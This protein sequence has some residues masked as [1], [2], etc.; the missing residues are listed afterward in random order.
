MLI[1]ELLEARVQPDQ[2][3]LYQV[4]EL[5]DDALREYGAFLDSNNDVDDID[6]LVELLNSYNDEDELPVE[7]HANHDPRK[8]PDEWLSAS[9]NWSREH[10]KSIDVF[11]H[12][13]NLE[14]V[15][16]PKTFK[17]VLMRMLGHELIHF[18]QYDKMRPGVI[19]N[20]RSGHMKGTELAAKTGKS[21]DWM[22][23]YLRDPH[24]IMAYAHDLASELRDL[25]DPAAALR[26][27]EAH[28]SALTS[29]DRYRQVF[30]VNSPQIRS[31]LKYAASYAQQ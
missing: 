22:R 6:E 15:Y 7:F 2:R 1:R 17:G 23:S 30:P 5:I 28:R 18:G 26:N 20:Y 21:A 8:D 11:L 31:L 12:A 25:E 27:P 10:G 9:A 13:K 16:G 29:Y 19:D 3:L 4:E 14:G 24:E